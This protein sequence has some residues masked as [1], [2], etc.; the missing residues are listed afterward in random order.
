V[1]ARFCGQCGSL[2]ATTV[3]AD[4][5]RTVAGVAVPEKLDPFAPLPK[6]PVGAL[7]ARFGASDWVLAGRGGGLK[8]DSSEELWLGFNDYTPDDNAGTYCAVL[9]VQ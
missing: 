2:C 6:V 1:H 4:G 8:P 9:I 7:L 3:N 5:A